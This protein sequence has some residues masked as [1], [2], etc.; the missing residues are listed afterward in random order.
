[1]QVLISYMHVITIYVFIL[2]HYQFIKTKKKKRIE[3]A[4]ILHLIEFQ[5][6]NTLKTN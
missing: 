4:K 6:I 3:N 2:V 1:M 5:E